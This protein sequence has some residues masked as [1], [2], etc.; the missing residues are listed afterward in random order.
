VTPERVTRL[1]ARMIEIAVD[2]ALHAQPL[3]YAPRSK[4]RNCGH[5]N[6]FTKPECRESE[7]ERRG[8]TFGRV[9]V[10]PVLAGKAPSDFRSRSEVFG[11]RH[12]L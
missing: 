1:D 7:I 9:A 8:R 5:R 6:D 11:E 10:S 4:I 12:V 2:V 3:H